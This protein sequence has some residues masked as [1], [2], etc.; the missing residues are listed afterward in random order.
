MGRQCKLKLG[1]GS[2]SDSDGFLRWEMEE[3]REDKQGKPTETMIRR[4]TEND[5]GHHI[6]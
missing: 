4:R 1:R 2:S 5:T 3:L 6:A